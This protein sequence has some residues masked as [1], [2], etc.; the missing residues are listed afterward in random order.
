MK[1]RV[2]GTPVAAVADDKGNAIGPLLVNADP[3]LEIHTS[4]AVSWSV[5]KRFG[6]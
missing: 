3:P 5:K 2:L 4:K 6:I 1:G